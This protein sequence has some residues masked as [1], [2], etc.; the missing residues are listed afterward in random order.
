[1]LMI[2]NRNGSKIFET[3]ANNYVEFAG[4]PNR[5]LLAGDGL[6]PVGTYFYVLKFNDGLTPDVS[7]WVYIN[8]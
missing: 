3:K 6:V 8:Y 1:E 4:I 5:G 7:S 2:F